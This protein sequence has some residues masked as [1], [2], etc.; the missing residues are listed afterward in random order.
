M[1]WTPPTLSEELSEGCAG[2]EADP[3]APTAS[4]CLRWKI[5]SSQATGGSEMK[6]TV[7][8]IDIAKRVFVRPASRLSFCFTGG[9]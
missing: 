5:R 8:G 1:V 7:V 3:L 9:I 6:R 4:K 2:S